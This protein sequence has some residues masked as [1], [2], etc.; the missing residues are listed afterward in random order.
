MTGDEPGT[1]CGGA[2]E[3]D[4]GV[5]EEEGEG[6]TAIRT[7]AVTADDVVAALETNHQ[8][9]ETVVL[10]AT[11]PYSGRMRARLHVPTD[12][13][14]ADAD[15]QRTDDDR[16]RPVAGGGGDGDAAD[17]GRAPVHVHP[18]D[19]VSAAAPSYPRPAETEDELRAD[20]AVTYTVERHHERHR[21]AVA[22]WR[23]RVRAQFA[24]ETTIE[25]ARGEHTVDVVVLG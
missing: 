12:A 13:E 16:E 10:R 15:G 25:T 23:E 22:D 5:G 2:T 11:P 9:G 19:L 3:R 18:T 20:P 7:L 1:D 8:R 14:R 6:P 21:A 4:T 17:P 24:D